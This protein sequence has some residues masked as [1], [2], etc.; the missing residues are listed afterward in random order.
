LTSRKKTEDTDM[1]NT[2]KII[3]HVY[4]KDYNS[5]GSK[6]SRAVIKRRCRRAQRRAQRRA[7]N[8]IEDEDG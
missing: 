8:T 5:N 3:P 2:K 7:M 4:V 1:N 6:S